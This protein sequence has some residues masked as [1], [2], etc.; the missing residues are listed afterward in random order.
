MP[1]SFC[2]VKA[3]KQRCSIFM[4]V[5]IIPAKNYIHSQRYK[6]VLCHIS[7]MRIK[8][9]WFLQAILTALYFDNLDLISSMKECHWDDAQINIKEKI[10]YEITLGPWLYL[11]FSALLLLSFWGYSKSIKLLLNVFIQKFFFQI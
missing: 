5:E 7:V 8:H 9:L 11:L 10:S 3:V 1:L 2:S 4:K 6:L